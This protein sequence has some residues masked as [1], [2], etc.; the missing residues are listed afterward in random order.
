MFFLPHRRFGCI[1][2]KQPAATV[3]A[4]GDG[5]GLGALPGGNGG[6]TAGASPGEK[7]GVAGGGDGGSAGGDGG[8][9]GGAGGEGG[10]THE[11]TPPPVW[12][13]PIPPTMYHD[14][15]A[16]E[17]SLKRFWPSEA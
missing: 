14:V 10:M 13:K 15:H 7:G 8:A 9:N 6:G 3:G 16:L 12:K 2:P 11:P 5:G 4:I 17:A 1:G